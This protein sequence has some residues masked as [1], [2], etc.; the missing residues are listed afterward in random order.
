MIISV[1]F[2]ASVRT[3]SGSL[4][5]SEATGGGSAQCDTRQRVQ[6]DTRYRVQVRRGT[7]CKRDAA[8][9]RKL[10]G[11]APFQG[12]TAVP[13]YRGAEGVLQQLA[14][15][16]GREAG[17]QQK[18]PVSAKHGAPGEA[19][20]PNVHVLHMRRRVGEG[21]VHVALNAGPWGNAFVAV[22]VQR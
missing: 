22:R 7:G 19:L 15:T 1:S 4:D 13:L 5:R 2:L 17:N 21:G 18:G 8:C 10:A 11:Q 14:K 12:R 16:V 6:C 20:R 3:T 9:R